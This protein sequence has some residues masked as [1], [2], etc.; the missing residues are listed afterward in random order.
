MEK[1]NKNMVNLI[2]VIEIHLFP[3]TKY[4]NA[5]SDK[6]NTDQVL[7]FADPDSVI[8]ISMVTVQN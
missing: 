4:S 8:P 6:R 2:Y 7:Y 5:N 3:S 1:L